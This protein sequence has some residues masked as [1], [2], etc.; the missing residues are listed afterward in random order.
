MRISL[1]MFSLSI[2]ISLFNISC[3]N[4]EISNEESN[5][6]VVS[7]ANIDSTLLEYFREFEPELTFYLEKSIENYHLKAPP[8]QDKIKYYKSN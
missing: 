3:I 6:T 7:S 4:D 2:I 8:S 5:N 1:L